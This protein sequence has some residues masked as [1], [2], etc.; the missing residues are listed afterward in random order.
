[1]RLEEN[2]R[3]RIASRIQLVLCQNQIDDAP[4]FFTL[5]RGKDTDADITV[6]RVSSFRQ[7]QD[8][9]LNCDQPYLIEARGD[10]GAACMTG[11]FESFSAP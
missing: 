11:E 1:L 3:S 6:L 7:C 4:D 8:A 2:R 10:V 5:F 9:I